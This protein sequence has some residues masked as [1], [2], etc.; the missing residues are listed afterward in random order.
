MVC[1]LCID[2]FCGL[3][4][5]IFFYSRW[6]YSPNE[7]K[8]SPKCIFWYFIKA[9]ITKYLV[10]VFICPFLDHIYGSHYYWHDDSF[11][12]LIFAN[13]SHQTRLDT[14]SKARRPIKVGIKGGKRSGT[15]RYSNPAGL[16]CSWLT[17]CNVSLMRQAVSLTQMWVR[18]RM[19]VY[20]LN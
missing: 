6:S 3:F 4:W 5:V 20:G 9:E 12:V 14:R 18:A 11:N 8:S 7:M 2:V 17:W 16:C 15:G 1:I 10:N 13:V 19:P